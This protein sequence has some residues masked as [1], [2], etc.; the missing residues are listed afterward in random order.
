[1]FFGDFN[2]IVSLEEKEGGVPRSERLMDAFREAIDDCGV[3]DLG[4]KGSRFTWQRGNSPST[5]IRERLDRMLGDD[6]WCNLFPSWE[7]AHLPRY[8]SDHAP[9]LLKTG[10]N[11]QYRRNNKLFRFEAMW[12]SRDECAT[13]V[14]EAWRSSGGDDV[15]TRLARVSNKLACWASQIFGDLKKRKKNALSGLD[16]LQQRDQDASV[17]AQCHAIAG[18][19][20]AINRLEESY[21]HARARANEIRDGDKNTKYFHHKAS[22]RK[23][24]SCIKGL[25]D[26]NGVWKKGREE[27]NEV[28]RHYFEDLFMSDEPVDMDEA[29][30][31][32]SACV[33]EEMNVRLVAPPSDDEVREALFSMHPNKAPGIDG[34][35]AL[36]FQKFWHIVGQDIVRFV[37]D[38]WNGGV[39]LSV[40][41]KTCIVLIPKCESPKS[42][43]DFRPI[44]LCTVVYKILSKTLA[45]RLKVLLPSIISPNQSAFVPRRLI[46]DNALVAFEIFHAMKRRDV[47]GEGVCA[48]K[49]DMSKAYD[50]VEWCFLERVMEKMGF[51]VEWISK[52]MAC[53]SS[54]SF[55]FKV[56]GV[57]D[58][59]LVP[60]RGLRQ[61]DLISPYLFLLCADA[62]STLLSKAAHE[63]RIPGARICRG[64]PLVSHL[65]FADDSILFT[66]AS[67]QECSVVADIISKY[68]RAS[69]QKV[70]LSKTE[71]VFSSS[72]DV[73]RR[74]DIVSILGVQEVACQAKYLGLPTV[75]GRS[76]KV[77]FACIKERIWKKLQGWKEKLLSRPGKEVLLKSVA[78]A[79]PTY[80][81]SVFC[82]PSGLIDEIH[83]MFA[84]FWWGSNGVERKMHWHCWD[85]LCLPK[86]MGGLGFRDLHCF[87]L[88]LL[89]KQA[90]R[91]CQDGL[92]LLHQVL[93]ARYYRGVEFLEA[94]RGYNPSFTWRSIWGSKALLLE[95]LKWRVGNGER[96]SVWEDA[97]IIGDGSHCVPTPQ[98]AS[99]MDL[100]VSALIDPYTKG[101]D[102][103]LVHQTFREDEW[104]L[105]L[106]LPLSRFRSEDRRYWWPA[107]NGLFSVK[108]CY[109]L[110]KLG[111][112]RTWRL[113]HGEGETKL[114]S[115]VWRVQGPPKLQ[116]FIW[117]A[118]K[119]SLGVKERL[120]WRH[121]CEEA[122]CPV[123]GSPSETIGHALFSCTIAQEVWKVSTYGPLIAA[124]PDGPFDVVFSWLHSRCSKEEMRTL[125]ALM[126]VVWYC[127]N[128]RVFDQETL[129][130]PDVAAN[131]VR[132]V[133]EYCGYSQRVFQ[134]R[135]GLQA[136]A[137][138]WNAPP[139]M[140]L[141]ANFD[142][143]ISP[144]GETGLGV[145]F[146][147]AEGRVCAMG[148]RRV[149]TQWD[150]PTAGAMAALYAVELACR[151]GYGNLIFEGDALLVVNAVKNKC[152]GGSPMFHIFSDINRMCLSFESLSFSHVKRAGNCVA[153]LLA[154]WE[155]AGNTEFVWFESFPQSISTL[156]EL[157]LL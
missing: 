103:D 99:D 101:W 135:G 106:N 78:Q 136:S 85:S 142:A 46:T 37:Q 153:H 34:L 40:V 61:G 115:N 47:R 50:R 117:R 138:S 48:L 143:H 14:E 108:S 38:W 88:A 18:D 110:G 16:E 114:W 62:F 63:K 70:N 156:A 75:I 2:E 127:R 39:D 90:W 120:Q 56:N 69:G 139:A 5:L 132:L 27:M 84:R 155:C 51:C 29:L 125:C 60:S 43:K 92:S 8:R 87:N 64:A 4:F 28:V 35:H 67:V 79:I 151:F 89:A 25:L 12:L 148:V 152:D 11:D 15:S 31:G 102:V 109:W 154:R 86:S 58:G 149:A 21:W 121:I 112:L 6:E 140:V 77:T 150:V 97:W 119:G 20:D 137:S 76:K 71:V 147:D 129:V 131:F 59:L 54:V 26:E 81:M 10:I 13:V 98:E 23:R 116:H 45:N 53:I 130:A 91:L 144:N 17:I 73:E 118:C 44:S 83:A 32:L 104:P 95:G 146:R 107:R 157:D 72:V 105:I 49:L 22:Q 126:W 128:K 113:Q 24:R 19:L 68:E 3:K 94:R 7:V 123:C 9:L 33:S 74:N 36:F 111:H 141:K 96:I 57:V 80:M 52:V 1:M 100:K 93:K 30:G 124:A 55:T 122:S 42:M 66:K 41:N 145:V 65:F 134:P 133:D 82:L